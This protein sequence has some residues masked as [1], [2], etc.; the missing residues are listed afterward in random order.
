MANTLHNN[1]TFFF[2]FDTLENEVRKRDEIINQLQNR[3]QEL[4]RL[5]LPGVTPCHVTT[6]LHSLTENDLKNQSHSRTSS[7]SDDISGMDE[8]FM[9]RIYFTFYV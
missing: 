9:V 2:R 5:G 3:I 8:G 6:E 4:E 1:P 7:G